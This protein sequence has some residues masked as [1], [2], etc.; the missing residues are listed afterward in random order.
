MAGGRIEHGRQNYGVRLKKTFVN[1]DAIIWTSST[2]DARG[3]NQS[4][5][6]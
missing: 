3:E 2:T 4:Q 5:S 1:S 6:M